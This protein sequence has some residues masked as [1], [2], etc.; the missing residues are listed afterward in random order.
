MGNP[1]SRK[2]VFLA[3]GSIWKKVVHGKEF[4]KKKRHSIRGWIVKVRRTV[5]TSI[6][7]ENIRKGGDRSKAETSSLISAAGGEKNKKA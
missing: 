7:K 4:G 1:G 6:A 2:K 3:G 5:F